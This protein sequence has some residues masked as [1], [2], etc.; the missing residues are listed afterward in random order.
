MASASEP[1]GQ[2]GSE[3]HATSEE[4][5]AYALDR[6]QVDA[7]LVDHISA[8]AICQPEVAWFDTVIQDLD[9]YPGCPSVDA[10]TR[11]ALGE[12]PEDEV[13]VVAAH[14]RECSA[15]ADEVAISRAAFPSDVSEVREEAGLMAAIRRVVATLVPDAQLAQ[16]DVADALGAQ[17]EPKSRSYQAGDFS[18]QLVAERDGESYV[19]TGV[20]T[21]VSSTA[22]PPG[23][24]NEALLY[25]LEDGDDD[26]RP[27]LIA[28]APLEADLSFDL[29]DIPAGSYRLE[30]LVG[31]TLLVFSSVTVP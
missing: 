14:L 3:R 21:T 30:A 22:N 25:S 11:F 10:L 5:A 20:I 23:I 4:L 1:S 13:L 6:S 31:E 28:H 2:R 17:A 19:V 15:C 18:V 26:Q 7:A 9:R 12:S 29:L 27:R 8:C 16:R 24:A